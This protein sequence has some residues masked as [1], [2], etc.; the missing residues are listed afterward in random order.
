MDFIKSHWEDSAARWGTAHAASWGD[1]YA[2]RLEIETVG[3]H[4]QDG[5]TVLDAGC[6]NG[7][8][9]IEQC[10]THAF[11][12]VVG[13][14]FS[15]KMIEA[16]R[17]RLRGTPVLCPIEFHVGDL[18]ALP[19][20]D[21]SFDVVYTTRALINLPTWADQQVAI[22]ECLRLAKPG[23]RVVLSEAFWEPLCKLNALRAVLGLAPLVEHD[24]NRY[25]KKSALSAFLNSRDIPFSSCD[26]SSV[27][28]AGTRLLREVIQDNPKRDYYSSELNAEFYRLERRFSGGD[29]GIQQL[30]LLSKSRGAS[31]EEPTERG[32]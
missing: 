21:K 11:T 15:E 1:L 4:L 24:F 12:K 16:A 22:L 7:F 26:F 18:R 28:Y 10:A 27:Y 13:I 25:L 29:I 9:L 20:A 6:G 32:A 8:A 5:D 2:I 14:D 19:F 3:S 31:R 30:F 17:E 23:G